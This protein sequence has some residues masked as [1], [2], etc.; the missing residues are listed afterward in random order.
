MIEQATKAVAEDGADAIIFGCT[1][2]FG[3]AETVRNGLLAAGHDVPVIDPVPTAIQVAAGLVEVK[4]SHSKS[5]YPMP[6][7]KNISGY[8]FLADAGRLDAAE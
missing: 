8:E 2:M 7:V 4:L 3:W 6:P 5:A 1:G